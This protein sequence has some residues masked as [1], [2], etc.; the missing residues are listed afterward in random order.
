MERSNGQLDVI[1]KIRNL[2]RDL[3]LY[4]AEVVMGKRTE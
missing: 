2:K 3:E 4:Q 1:E